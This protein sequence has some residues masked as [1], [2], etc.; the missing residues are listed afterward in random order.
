V[1]VVRHRHEFVQEKT[2][3]PAVVLQDIEKQSRHFVFLEKRVSSV[4]DGRD[5][6]S[7]DFL[8]GVA[9]MPPALK[10]IF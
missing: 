3:F 8:R 4:S 10:R 9:Q 5:E 2:A 7:S 6:E 1:E